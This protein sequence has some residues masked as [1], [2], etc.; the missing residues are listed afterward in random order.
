[1]IF[2]VLIIN[3]NYMI[4]SQK[5]R[6]FYNNTSYADQESVGD[7]MLVLENENLIPSRVIKVFA[8]FLQGKT[9]F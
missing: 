9:F 8:Q 2:L 3:Y 1:M 7:E 6:H 4:A 5:Y